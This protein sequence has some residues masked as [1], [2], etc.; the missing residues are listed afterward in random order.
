MAG[1]PVVSRDEEANQAVTE[2]LV[3]GQVISLQEA[4]KIILLGQIFRLLPPDQDDAGDARDG[5]QEVVHVLGVWRPLVDLGGIKDDQFLV[6]HDLL[7]NLTQ[8]YGLI[9]GLVV[10]ANEVVV[11]VD[12][13]IVHGLDVHHWLED[14]NI[15]II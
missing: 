14:K 15:V 9:D 12:W 6:D 3:G 4:P 11:E 13:Q 2:L 10:A 8:H 5:F 1:W 7:V